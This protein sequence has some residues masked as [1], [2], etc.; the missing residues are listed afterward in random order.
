MSQ[1][2]GGVSK[3]ELEI[4]L[5]NLETRIRQLLSRSS[6]EVVRSVAVQIAATALDT[7]AWGDVSGKPS[8][9]PPEAHTH[10]EIDITDLDK[11]T[12][13]EVDAL[14]AAA[15]RPGITYRTIPDGVTVEVFAGEQ[16]LVF[17]ELTVEGELIL[18]GELVVL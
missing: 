9:F 3:N 16:Y 18:E 5:R 14:I 2:G 10:T 17:Q 1:Y 12:Q 15:S 7:V 13:A 4:R 6:D 11:Y 8:L